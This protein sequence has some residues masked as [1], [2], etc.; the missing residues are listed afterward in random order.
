MYITGILLISTSL[1]FMILYTNL[2]T[3]NYTFTQYLIYIIKRPECF[4]GLLGIILIVFALK[5]GHTH[6]YNSKL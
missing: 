3:I 5:K 1:T 4:L 6:E 2:L